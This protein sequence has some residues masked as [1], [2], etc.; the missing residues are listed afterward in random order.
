MERTTA[1]LSYSIATKVVC[2][3]ELNWTI[4]PVQ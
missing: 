1:H 4:L 2:S 3:I